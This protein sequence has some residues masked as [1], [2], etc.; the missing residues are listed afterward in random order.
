M[1]KEMWNERYSADEYAYGTSPNE[2][3]RKNIEQLPPGKIL[4]PGDGE[5]RNAVYAAA[6]GWDVTAFDMSDEAEAA[7]IVLVRRIVETLT[8]RRPERGSFRTILHGDLEGVKSYPPHRPLARQGAWR[9]M[10]FHGETF[11]D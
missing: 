6:L 9:A 4:L 7:R 2:F 8:R 5:G 11:V 1:S 10:L 3:F